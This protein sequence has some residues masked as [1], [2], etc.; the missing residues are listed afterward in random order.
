[1]AETDDCGGDWIVETIND[2]VGFRTALW[3][4]GGMRT[5]ASS[6]D[7]GVFDNPTFGRVMILDGAYQITAQDEF[8]YHEMMAHM[9]LFAHGAAK[10]VCIIGGGDGGVA[11]EVLRHPVDT[12]TMVEIDPSVIDLAKEVFP[13]VSNGAFDDPR[14]RL[15]I[16]DGARFVEDTAER[17]DVL[18]VDAPDP[19]GEGAA[20]FTPDFYRGCRAI[21]RD[22]G[23]MVTQS[24][25]P[26][27][28][29][30]WLRDHAATLRRAFPDVGFFLT[31]VP[32]YTGGPMAH[33]F[34]S[35][36]PDLKRTPVETIAARHE[37]LGRFPTKYWTPAVH[38]AAFVL[39][40]YVE[41]VVSS[42]I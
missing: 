16:A 38:A 35:A 36:N 42:N 40:A 8:I 25:M 19:V 18:I 39:P 26:F 7:L 6:Q 33:G 13:Q 5:L 22:G 21:V 14:L 32:S 34:S 29:P 17:Y 3:A 23:V 28:K 27:L 2:P 31:T 1:M 9:P 10:S 15:V 30:D 11:R 41:A 24:G 20:L 37:A 4:D 12:L